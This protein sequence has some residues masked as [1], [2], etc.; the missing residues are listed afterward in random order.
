[1][2]NQIFAGQLD[3]VLS[4]AFLSP[5]TMLT[6]AAD[7]EQLF[8]DEFL[9]AIV[10]LQYCCH[11]SAALLLFAVCLSIG[12]ESVAVELIERQIEKLVF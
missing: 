8:D 5:L 2:Q 6:F 3:L 7:I 12:R 4:A 1:M 11:L 9:H 10:A